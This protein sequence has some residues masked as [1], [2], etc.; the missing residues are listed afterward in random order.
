VQIVVYWERVRNYQSLNGRVSSLC[1]NLT[2]VLGYVL[3]HEVAH[4]LLG[5]TGHS[6]AGVMRAHWGLPEFLKMERGELLLDKN[7]SIAIF[8]YCGGW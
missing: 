7:Q 1:P 3:V 2:T 6:E 5:S 8:R 4:V